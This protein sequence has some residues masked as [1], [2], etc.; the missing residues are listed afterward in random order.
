MQFQAIRML[1]WC[2]GRSFEE[3]Q[4]WCLVG[5]VEVSMITKVLNRDTIEKPERFE[6]VCTVNQT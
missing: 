1:C 4:V 3:G 5:S 2:I 6:D